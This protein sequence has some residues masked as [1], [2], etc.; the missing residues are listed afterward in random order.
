MPRVIHKILECAEIRQNLRKSKVP[1]L[2]SR[3]RATA[4]QGGCQSVIKKVGGILPKNLR[5]PYVSLVVTS[6]CSLT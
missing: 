6:V 2:Q 1:S 5:I 4:T 3:Q